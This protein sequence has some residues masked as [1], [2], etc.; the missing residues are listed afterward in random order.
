MGN[1]FYESPHKLATKIIP[2]YVY[3][4]SIYSANLS[5]VQVMSPGA[6]V[7]IRNTLSKN[8]TNNWRR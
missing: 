2:I 4:K 5:N 3:I 7:Q 6:V 1:V 8:I